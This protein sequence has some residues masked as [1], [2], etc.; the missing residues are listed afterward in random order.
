MPILETI[1][2]N[3]PVDGSVYVERPVA[4]DQADRRGTVSTEVRRLVPLVPSP[5]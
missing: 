5:T 1:K 2:I 3:S 4:T